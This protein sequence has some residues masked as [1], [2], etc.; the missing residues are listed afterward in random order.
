MINNAYYSQD[1]HGPYELPAGARL[2]L[3]TIWGMALLRQNG[4]DWQQLL[5]DNQVT[6]P[7]GA[8]RELRVGIH[9]WTGIIAREVGDTGTEPDPHLD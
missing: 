8:D 5:R 4:G 9:G 7:E 6:I 3:Y 1:A 2:L